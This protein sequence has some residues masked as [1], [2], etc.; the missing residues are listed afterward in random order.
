MKFIETDVFTDSV[1]EKSSEDEYRTLQTSLLLRPT[2]GTLIPGTGG[3]RKLRFGTAVK[4]KRGG[5]RVIYYLH[6]EEETIYLLYMY[7]K[8]RRDDLTPEQI[9]MLSR[10]VREEFK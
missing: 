9:R 10:M 3:L 8:I 6:G 1:L 5:L 2:Q 4:G 7:P